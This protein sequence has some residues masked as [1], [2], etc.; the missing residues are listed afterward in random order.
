MSTSNTKPPFE[1]VR[2]NGTYSAS[3]HPLTPSQLIIAG[4]G[5]SGLLLAILLAQHGIP[6]LVLEA[7]PHLDTRLRATQYGTPATRVFR[8]AG[9][10]PDIRAAS[11]PSF[12]AICWRRVADG[13]KLISIDLSVTA[14]EEDRMTV[15]QLGHI[16]QIMYRHCVVRYSWLQYPCPQYGMISVCSDSLPY[17][18]L[19]RRR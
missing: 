16:I 14:D 15:L 3:I 4:A 7:W 9:L 18:V 13:E 2:P 19:Q 6:T 11:I 8:R 12:P 1:K 5:P 10:L 17:A